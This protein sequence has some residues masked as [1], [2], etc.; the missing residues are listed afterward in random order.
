MSNEKLNY[1]SCHKLANFEKVQGLEV[2]KMQG[3]MILNGLLLQIERLRESRK[4]FRILDIIFNKHDKICNL[5]DLNCKNRS[6][7][8]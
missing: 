6:K 3:E 4:L 2:K 1:Q 5:T 8:L 7:Y